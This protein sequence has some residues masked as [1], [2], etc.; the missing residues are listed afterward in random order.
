VV[1]RPVSPVRGRV[2]ARRRLGS[3]RRRP[4][5]RLP[6]RSSPRRLVARPAH[7][8]RRFVLRA[9][10]TKQR[11]QHIPSVTQSSRARAPSNR[12]SEDDDQNPKSKIKIQNLK[13]PSREIHRARAHSTPSP[14]RR[15]SRA[16]CSAVSDLVLD[17]SLA[18]VPRPTDRFVAPRRRGQCDRSIASPSPTRRPID[19]SVAEFD[20]RDERDERE[21]RDR[22]ARRANSTTRVAR[23]VV[24]FVAFGAI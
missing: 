5:S 18:R 16:P 22:F 10:T 2:P 12:P 6:A 4:L 11:Y 3:R 20:E 1:R 13:N 7:R 23:R 14:P 19:R 21:I 8:H 17:A 15:R 9:T 24:A